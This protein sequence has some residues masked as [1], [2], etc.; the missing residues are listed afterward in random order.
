MAR[1]LVVEDATSTLVGLCEL[2][3][4]AGY[5]VVGAASFEEG[6]RLADEAA[7]DL[8]LIDVRLGRHN[9]L[10]LV[11]RERSAHPQRPIIVTTAFPDSGLEAEAK[12][13]G[14]EF[15]EKP[16]QASSLIAMI[17]RLLP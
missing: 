12:R 2:L 4:D 6:T 1:I 16:I 17:R 13:Y 5:D 8:L 10:H 14:A 15:M 11:L 7:P 9:G 3:K